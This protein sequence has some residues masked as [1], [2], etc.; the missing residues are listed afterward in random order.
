MP[1]MASAGVN[2]CRKSSSNP[3]SKLA[4]SLTRSSRRRTPS[5]NSSS[6]R[7]FGDLARNHRRLPLMVL[8]SPL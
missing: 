2:A 4:E 6:R 1:S 8:I 7:S 3:L 5:A